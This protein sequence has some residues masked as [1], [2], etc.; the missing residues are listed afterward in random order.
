M[1]PM[2]V[3]LKMLQMNPQDATFYIKVYLSGSFKQIHLTGDVSKREP[4][5]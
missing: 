3:S 5:L 2:S 4:D 1:T